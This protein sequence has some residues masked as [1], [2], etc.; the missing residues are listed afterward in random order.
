MVSQFFGGISSLMDVGDNL[1]KKL[2]ILSVVLLFF[3]TVHLLNVYFRAGLSPSKVKATIKTA[4]LGF[5]ILL[6]ESQVQAVPPYG[7]VLGNAGSLVVLLC[8][9]S[10]VTYLVVDMYLH[11]RMKKQVP[12]FQR[13]LL[14]ILIF[15]IF[16]LAALRI[17]FRIDVSS[18][19]TTTTVLTAAIAF[20]MQTTIAN[21]FSG[22][23]V[24]N[25]ANLRRNTWISIKDHD[26]TGEIVNVGFRYTT[27]RTLD[28]RKVMVPNNYIMQNIVLNLGTRGEGA[29]TAVHL[30]VG[31]GYDLPPEKAIDIMSRI[32]AEESHIMK[33]P[34]PLV[35]VHDFLDSSIEYD[36]KYFLDDYSSSQTTRGSVLKKIWYAITREG[37][38]VP[39][40]HR[41]IITK[42][43][44]EPFSVD[45]KT[46]LAVLKR[47][48]ILQS[49][50]E[51][52]FRQLSERVHVKVFGT[53]EVVVRQ[54][55][56][57]DS[58][59]IV[60]RGLLNV[61]VDDA[62]VGSLRE[63]EVFGEMS[64]LTGERRKATVAAAS[65]VHLLE[66][67]KEDILPLLRA[68][69]DLLE[70]LSSILAQREEMNLER[71]KR[72]ALSRA[73]TGRKDAFRSKLK[74]FF[75]F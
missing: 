40:P 74:A 56:E 20:A 25:D 61:Y 72:E 37:H 8:L 14:S 75:G 41:E 73:G 43:P 45:D 16:A 71:K 3:L 19:L 64:L 4:L 65:E 39:F 51:E 12:S 60:R 53:G 70:K 30:K 32:L 28:N 54:R 11:Y 7:N 47:T 48:E 46:V 57:G 35:V 15:T 2:I 24:Q 68:N 69:P 49:L 9:A 17:V 26:I 5:V 1:V 58:L 13:D 62:E 21:I 31:L 55:D 63:G 59:F 33:D 52:E 66:I 44:R 23:Y 22:F 6:L 67:S 29:K 50:G 38:S 36:L 10:L 42:S 34:K 27:L 18:I